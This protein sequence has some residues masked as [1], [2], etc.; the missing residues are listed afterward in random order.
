MG[1]ILMFSAEYLNALSARTGFQAVSLQKQMSLLILLRELRRHPLLGKAYALRGG[2][3]INLIWFNLPRLS[4]DVDLNYIGSPSLETMQRERPVL[5][6]EL[7]K[8]VEAQG[9]T[10]EHTAVEH[11]GGKWRL[12][13]RSAFGG[14]FTLELDLNYLMRVP[15]GTLQSREFKSL[16]PDY[17]TDFAVVSFEELFAGKIK[18]LL[19]RSTG[20]D[21]YDVYSLSNDSANGDEGKLRKALILIGITSDYDWRKKDFRTL[22]TIDQKMVDQELRPLLRSTEEL[23]VKKMKQG[24]TDFVSG[25]IRYDDQERRFLDR[26]LDDG[27]YEPA[28]LFQVVEEAERLRTHPAVLWK[29]QTLRKHLGL[30]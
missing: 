21:L 24:V 26:F 25:L 14:N 15:I 20:R 30:E 2:T 1:G 8:I 13:A 7:K 19:E 27:M 5:E 29:L 3:A 12:R 9:I 17:T 16:D 6:K 11:A 22:D 10:V 18:A 4:V 28:L 23:D